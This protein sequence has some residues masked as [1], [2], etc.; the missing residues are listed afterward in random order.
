MKTFFSVISN[1]PIAKGSSFKE[2][3]HETPDLKP[4][5]IC[6][7]VLKYPK[8]KQEISQLTCLEWVQRM[9]RLKAKLQKA[10]EMYLRGNV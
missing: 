2:P 6:E 7:A 9:T 3:Q 1:G 10:I 4:S 5:E 8:M